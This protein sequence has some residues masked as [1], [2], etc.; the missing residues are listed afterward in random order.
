MKKTATPPPDGLP[1]PYPQTPDTARAYVTAHGIC[2]ADVARYYRIN[3]YALFDVLRG[4]GRGMRGNC[5]RAAIL[6]GLKPDPQ[7]NTNQSNRR[8]A[9]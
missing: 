8:K 9:A 5:H 7:A 2:L 4:K 3:R 6:L 1:I